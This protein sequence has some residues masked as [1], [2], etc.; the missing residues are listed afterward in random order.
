MP[1]DDR[2]AHLATGQASSTI[3][4]VDDE[5][6]ACQTLEALLLNQGYHLALATSG[7]QALAM[8]AELA[9]D[10]ILLDVMMPDMDGFEVCRRLRSDP[11]LAIVPVIMV[12]ALDDRG[13]RLQGLAAGADDFVSKPFDRAE[14]R[15]RVRTITQLNRYRRLLAEQARFEWVVQNARDGYLVTKQDGELIYA[16]PQA[17]AYLGLSPEEGRMAE[18]QAGVSRRFVDLARQQYHC[19][20]QNAWAAWGSADAGSPLYL[21]RPESHTA[22]AFWL[23][24]DVFNLSSQLARERLIRLQDVTLQMTLRRNVWDFHSAINHKLRSPLVIMLNSLELQVREM[25]DLSSAEVAELSR[26]ALKSVTRLR[27]NIGD[28]LQ[29]LNACAMAKSG[30]C[31]KLSRLEAMVDE[32]VTYEGL[33]TV[34]VSLQDDLTQ[35]SLVLSE[36]AIELILWELV[37]N[38]K[39]FHPSR[40]PSV[41]VAAYR[42]ALGEATLKVS[43]DGLTLSPEQL[44]CLWIPYYQGEKFF[45]GQTEGMGLGLPMVA[46]LTWEV[47]GDCRLYNR[48][49]GPGVVV[50]LTVPLAEPDPGA[51]HLG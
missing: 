39:K 9:P 50:E 33:S 49:D 27:D 22:Q 31:F 29:Y 4:I 3:L 16:N 5:P 42:S 25:A 38:A 11:R 18:I 32:I 17:C 35:T 30:E 14:L 45:T 24:V 6:G 40:A 8:A 23:Q 20:P 46:A 12:T 48:P 26:L 7:Q 37:E 1:H 47:G 19:E 41:D 28:I 34:N 2:Y 10:V 13:S 36:R 43:D 44:A 51:T 21:V 15:A